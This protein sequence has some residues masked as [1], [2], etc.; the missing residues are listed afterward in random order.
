MI[1]NNCKKLFFFVRFVFFFCEGIL[2]PLYTSACTSV[3]RFHTCV[4][5]AYRLFIFCVH[6]AYAS[7][8]A[9]CL[10]FTH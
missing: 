9:F 6:V 7:D 4:C 2:A 8:N 1:D 5:V 10:A 3:C